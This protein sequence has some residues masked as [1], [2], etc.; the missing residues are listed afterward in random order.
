[1]VGPSDRI[2]DTPLVGSQLTAGG[3]AGVLY[4]HVRA[5]HLRGQL[6]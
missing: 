1:L 3:A 5:G 2:A 6:G 4:A